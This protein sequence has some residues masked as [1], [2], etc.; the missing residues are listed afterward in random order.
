M[1]LRF[2]T[3]GGKSRTLINALVRGELGRWDERG[4][5]AA[6]R[7]SLAGELVHVITTSLH[8]EVSARLRERRGTTRRSRNR[9]RRQ[10]IACYSRARGI[11]IAPGHDEGIARS[12]RF[13]PVPGESQESICEN[14]RSFQCWRL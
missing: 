6:A 11:S 8:R 2:A 5:F 10:S 3:K 13:F 1:R 12:P 4:A 7:L 14:W 9:N